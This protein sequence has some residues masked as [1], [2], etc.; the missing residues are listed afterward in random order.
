MIL[1]S[2]LDYLIYFKQ[3]LLEGFNIFVALKLHH[4]H[5]DDLLLEFL[6]VFLHLVVGRW[7]FG[8]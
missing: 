1:T 6:D 8:V 4:A 2:S 7:A 5:L 3:L